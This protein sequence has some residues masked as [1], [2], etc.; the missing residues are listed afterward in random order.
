MA[1]TQ[2]IIIGL[3]AAVVGLLLLSAI[4]MVTWNNSIVPLSTIKDSGV[5]VSTWQKMDF[6]TSIIFTLFLLFA[7]SALVRGN[8]V[9]TVGK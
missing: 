8:I 9:Y 1:S 2:K 7:G 6:K 5:S 4:I 3:V